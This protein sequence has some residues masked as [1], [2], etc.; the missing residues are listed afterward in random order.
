ML[1]KAILLFCLSLIG[2]S[3]QAQNYAENIAHNIAKGMMDSL[4]LSEKQRLKI[5]QVNLHLHSQKMQMR[6]KYGT[7]DSL[8]KKIQQ[9]ENTRDSLYK[10]VLPAGIYLQYKTKKKTLIRGQ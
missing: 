1:N 5:Y 9:V 3:A 10:A 4:N 2:I 7:T 8:S 6:E